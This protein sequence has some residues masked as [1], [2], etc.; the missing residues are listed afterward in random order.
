MKRRKRPA[1]SYDHAIS[2][3]FFLLSL[4]LIVTLAL[5]VLFYGEPFRFW[6]HAFSD[7]GNTVTS[8]GRRNVASRM[9]FSVGMMVECALMLRIRARYGETQDLRHRTIKRWLALLGAVAFLVAICPND[10]NHTIHSVGVGTVVG[11]IYL[12]TMVFH[13]ELEPRIPA[14]L[15]YVDLVII[16][17]AVFSYAWAFFANSPFKQSLQKTCIGGVFFALERACM[18]TEE[19]YRPHEALAFL[20]RLQQ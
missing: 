14:R 1:A 12:F 7:L 13:L 6:H 4:V 18:A 17:V 16:Q 5:A 10:V 19:S 11:V 20:Q 2:E 8:R 9:V 15:F 3:L